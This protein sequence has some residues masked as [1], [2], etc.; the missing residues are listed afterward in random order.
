[1]VVPGGVGAHGARTMHWFR[2]RAKGFSFVALFAL[3]LQLALS[4][5][6]LHLN[7]S[8]TGARQS[9]KFFTVDDA[10]ARIAA[11]DSASQDA[12]EHSDDYC[13]ICAVIHLARSLVLSPAPPLLLPGSYAQAQFAPEDAVASAELSRAP[14]NARAP[15][16]A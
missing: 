8:V 6:H 15:P 11:V 4:F 14:F 12:P 16:T 2:S 10:T 9:W 1:M 3:S 13:A 7:A 5:G